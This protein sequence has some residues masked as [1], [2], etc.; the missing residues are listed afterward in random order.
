MALEN[1]SHSYKKTL[2]LCSA[3]LKYT[4]RVIT[5]HITASFP[6]LRGSISYL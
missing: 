2:L 4:L 1:S 3:D 6:F 5:Y